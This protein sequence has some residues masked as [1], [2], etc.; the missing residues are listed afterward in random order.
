[1]FL[2]SLFFTSLYTDR[3]ISYRAQRGALGGGTPAFIGVLPRQVNGARQVRFGDDAQ[4]RQ[5]RTE[6]AASGGRHEPKTPKSHGIPCVLGA[7]CPKEPGPGSGTAHARTHAGTAGEEHCAYRVEK[8]RISAAT[9]LACGRGPSSSASQG[10]APVAETVAHTWASTGSG[11]DSCRPASCT[12]KGTSCGP[13]MVGH[14]KAYDGQYGLA[15]ANFHFC[16]VTQGGSNVAFTT[17][18]I[19]Y[20]PACKSMTPCIWDTRHYFLELH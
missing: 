7:T 14:D 11:T 9:A 2:A 20:A 5:G 18:R 15:E 3:S 19:S 8:H 4:G 12:W 13:R 10:A 6:R 1:M 17:P 16:G